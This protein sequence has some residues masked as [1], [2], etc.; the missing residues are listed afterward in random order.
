[1]LSWQLLVVKTDS[2][3]MEIEEDMED[4]ERIGEAI[5]QGQTQ[6]YE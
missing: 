6:G 3:G 1:M 5:K 2:E 4:L